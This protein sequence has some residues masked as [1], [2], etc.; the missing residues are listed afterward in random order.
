MSVGHRARRA[1]KSAA[2]PPPPRPRKPRA[3]RFRK[4]S[5]IEDDTLA[6]IRDGAA[7][8][9]AVFARTD[10]TWSFF[11]IIRAVRELR[12]QGLLADTGDALRVCE[13]PSARASGV[14]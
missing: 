5:P 4:L 8:V 9:A 3:V 14:L 12:R 10:V 1:R 6:H 7:S 11:S 2:P 13:R